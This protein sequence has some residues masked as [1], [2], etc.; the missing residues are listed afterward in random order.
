ML[1]RT[2]PSTALLQP[3]SLNFIDLNYF[4][5]RWW[6]RQIL[7]DLFSARLDAPKGTLVCQ[8]GLVCK[9]QYSES[10]ISL[11]KIT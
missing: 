10:L 4:Q 3:N 9:R 1:I 5:V 2:F 6:L 7:W 11:P 8:V